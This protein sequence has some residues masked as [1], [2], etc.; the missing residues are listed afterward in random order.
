[1]EALGRPPR[2]ATRLT[3]PTRFVATIEPAAEFLG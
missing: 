1:V 2:C 3:G